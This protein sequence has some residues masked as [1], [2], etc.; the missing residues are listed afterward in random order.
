MNRR[1]SLTK[2]FVLVFLATLL[3][4][5]LTWVNYYYVLNNPGGSDFL[6]RWVGARKFLLQGISPYSEETTHEIHKLFYGRSATA[7][8]DQVLFAYPLYSII[9]FTPFSLISDYNISR[10]I[11]M[12]VLEIAITSIAIISIYL[13]HWR[14]SPIMLGFFL[15]FTILW[16]YGI[17]PLI[18]ANVSIIVALMVLGAFFLL[19][20]G[21]E[22]L[23]GFLLALSTIKPQMV[24]FLI[25]FIL[26]WSIYRWRW[27]LLT[28]F[29]SSLLVMTGIFMVFVP[30]WISQNLLQ[31]LAYPAYTN[32]TT[33][34]ECFAVWLPGIGR[35]LGW[36]L[37]MGVT[38]VMLVEWW[39]AIKKDNG[40]FVWAAY[41]T[42]VLT[43]L[44]GIQTATENYILLFP[45][46]VMVFVTWDELYRRWGQFLII[47]TCLL[48][49]FGIW[50]LFFATIQWGN[51]PVQAPIM[52]FPLPVFLLISMYLIRKRILNPE[53]AQDFTEETSSSKIL[54][55]LE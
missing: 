21:H 19:R 55:S 2:L 27:R 45:A 25:I 13:F 39:L 29:L 44:I 1:F 48:F 36:I 40:W 6:P 10:A 7:G 54:S 28:S 42:L 41:L 52:F 3:L 14:L 4:G 8:E 49:F 26:L 17:R 53:P 20:S 31:M 33:P 5:L 32:T 43:Q 50:W 12:T 11:W 34:G 47:V 18:N 35:Q 22:W 51:Q 46:L 9:V 16:Y 23:A 38:V 24:V 15:L 30:N 37:T